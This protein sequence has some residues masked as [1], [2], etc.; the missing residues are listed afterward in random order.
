MPITLAATTPNIFETLSG[1]FSRVDLLAHPR[2][3]VDVLAQMSI[4]WAVVLLIAGLV[5]LLNGYKLYRWVTIALAGGIGGVA[6]YC[7]GQRISA[8]F[9]VAGCLAA[10]LAVVA[11]PLMKYA[12]AAMG[13]I[14]GAFLGANLWGACAGLVDSSSRATV[15]NTYWVGALIGLVLCGMLAFVLFKL[16]VVIFTSVS[17]ATIAMLGVLGL[18]L[19]VPAWK[20]GITS[21]AGNANAMVLPLLVIVPAIIGLILQQVKPETGAA[22]GSAGGAKPA[23]KPA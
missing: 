16:S 15:E 13:G 6:G 12:V 10:L 22:G 1:V 5:C 18:V 3:L 21:W 23:A 20:S 2:G 7:L 14:V 4:V 19:Q 9:I 11:Y 17:G 8:E